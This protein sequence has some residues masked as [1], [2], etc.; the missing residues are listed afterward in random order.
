MK[1]LNRIFKSVEE[2]LKFAF[3]NS[4]ELKDTITSIFVKEEGIMAGMDIFSLFTLVS[5]KK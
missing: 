4:S 2:Q 1:C 5:V 3:N